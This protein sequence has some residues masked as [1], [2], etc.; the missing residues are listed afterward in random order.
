M[1]DD[2]E[3]FN[4]DFSEDE[5]EFE[6]NNAISLDNMLN[7]Q[8]KLDKKSSKH[9]RKQKGLPQHPGQFNLDYYHDWLEE[10][11]RIAPHLKVVANLDTRDWRARQDQVASK[12]NAIKSKS[13]DTN[14]AINAL[15]SELTD[16]INKINS[17]QNH[18]NNNFAHMA[19]K[20]LKDQHDRLKNIE[21]EY[22][23]I[24]ESKNDLLME[25]EETLAKYEEL[26]RKVADRVANLNDDLPLQNLQNSL[27]VLLREN[28]DMR[29]QNA[30]LEHQ[31]TQM[32]LERR[33]IL[34]RNAGS[35]LA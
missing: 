19:L 27:K 12:I 33:L 26:E 8:N 31:L 1:V 30:V 18:L 11:E 16:Q 29:L 28:K 22:R 14:P 7:Q 10:V 20:N 17:R 21:E 5:S 9:S 3:F 23:N 35:V 34:R 15:N 32:K 24:M 2:S 4:Q 6:D 25:K 13:K